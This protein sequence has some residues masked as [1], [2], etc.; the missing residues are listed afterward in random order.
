L[1]KLLLEDAGVDPL[2][3][4]LNVNPDKLGITIETTKATYTLVDL[5][6]RAY[7]QNELTYQIVENATYNVFCINDKR[8][9]VDFKRNFC[10]KYNIL[11]E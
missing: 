5:H 8:I 6:L 10:E 11:I 4:K 7:L 1:S 2:E 9:S 3:S